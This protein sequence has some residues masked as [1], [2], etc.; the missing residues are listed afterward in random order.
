[1]EYN[2]LKLLIKKALLYKRKHLKE[3]IIKKEKKVPVSKNKK[4]QLKKVY[5]KILTG[6]PYE[7]NI[8][9]FMKLID[10]VSDSYLNYEL[11]INLSEALKMVNELIQGSG[12]FTAEELKNIINITKG[13]GFP[14]IEHYA[15]GGK[16]ME[17]E[18]QIFG[19]H[20]IDQN[21]KELMGSLEQRR[22]PKNKLPAPEIT[23]KELGTT[24][25]DI[26]HREIVPTEELRQGLTN[27]FN[28]RLARILG[29]PQVQDTEFWRVASQI[30]TKRINTERIANSMV[31]I[32]LNSKTYEEAKQKA[33]EKLHLDFTKEDDLFKSMWKE[34]QRQAEEVKIRKTNEETTT[35]KNYLYEELLNETYN[36]IE[37][38]PPKSFY[39]PYEKHFLLPMLSKEDNK[40]LAKNIRRLS[41]L[42]GKTK[43]EDL[44]KIKDNIN[45]RRS[46]HDIEE[47]SNQGFETAIKKSLG[48][49][50]TYNQKINLKPPKQYK[51]ILSEPKNRLDI[52]EKLGYKP[53]IKK[54]NK[55]NPETKEFEEQLKGAKKPSEKIRKHY[56]MNLHYKKGKLVGNCIFCKAKN[57]IASQHH[58]LEDIE[59]EK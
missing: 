15:A 39:F 23:K 11:E 19:A 4:D 25:P 2:H 37:E 51:R 34:K 46:E 13:I 20:H 45:K 32:I 52:E 44:E 14:A 27:K 9:M 55:Y 10:M 49:K 22:D 41:L 40:E 3:D 6:T 33:K 16:P 47:L 53:I 57:V 42:G 28:S 54:L 21:V 12:D 43:K 30:K 8:P 50:I 7:D 31:D 58:H 48:K 17:K 29:M 18:T 26:I 56:L 24:I 36:L 38:H 35:I 59:V 1:M 5:K